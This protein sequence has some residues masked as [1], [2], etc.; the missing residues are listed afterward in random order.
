[1]ARKS[2]KNQNP[3]NH[4]ARCEQELRVAARSLGAE[5]QR[6]VLRLYFSLKPQITQ[7]ITLSSVGVCLGI[8]AGIF[9]A[10]AILSNSELSG[11]GALIC[12][13]VCLGGGALLGG[14]FLLMLFGSGLRAQAHKNIAAKFQD[15]ADIAMTLRLLKSCQSNLGRHCEWLLQ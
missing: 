11:F 1:M 3:R 15:N 14:Y 6:K 10:I 7:Y 4:L 13:L 8:V 9:L 2:K 5:K 12:I